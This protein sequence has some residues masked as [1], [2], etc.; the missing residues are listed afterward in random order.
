MSCFTYILKCKD[1][2]YYTGITNNIEKRLFEHNTGVSTPIQ[3]S[4]RPVELVYFEKFDNRIE[5]ARREKEIKG[6]RR[7]KKENLIAKFNTE[8]IRLEGLH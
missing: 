2:S 8:S 7:K 6:W 3:P 5:A 4:K 1:G